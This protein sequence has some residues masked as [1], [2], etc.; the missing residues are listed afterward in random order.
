MVQYWY[1][2]RTHQVEEG[3]QSDWRQLLGPYETRADAEQALAQV[4]RNNEAT[5]SFDED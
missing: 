3:P 5:D 1:N 2:V 4:Q